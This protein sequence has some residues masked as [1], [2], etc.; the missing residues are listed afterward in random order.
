MAEFYFF[1]LSPLCRLPQNCKHDSHFLLSS[2]LWLSSFLLHIYPRAILI[3]SLGCLFYL[4]IRIMLWLN[5]F[6]SCRLLLAKQLRTLRII[7]W[8]LS[9]NKVHSV[10]RRSPSM[11]KPASPL[12]P[13]SVP[14]THVSCSAR[15][16]LAALGTH[17][18]VWSCWD[19]YL[20]TSPGSTPMISARCPSK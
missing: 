20:F 18:S 8:P 13:P 17:K 16:Y 15:A 11:F 14:R 6:S 2:S 4:L 7:F 3:S 12:L 1:F 10:L 19:S 9:L 5:F